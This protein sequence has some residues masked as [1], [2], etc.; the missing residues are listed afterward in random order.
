MKENEVARVRSTHWK[1]INAYRTLVGKRERKR[2]L[3][4]LKC[5]WEDSITM[6]FTETELKYVYWNHLA[7][8]WAQRRSYLKKEINLMF[9]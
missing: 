9:P 6:H 4:R 3:G 7:E 8:T 5:E 1:M 2:I